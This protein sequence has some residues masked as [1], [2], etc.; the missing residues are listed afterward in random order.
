MGAE[1]LLRGAAGVCVNIFGKSHRLK[2]RG[3][4]PSGPCDVAS[5]RDDERD[6]EEDGA[7]LFHEGDGGKCRV[8]SE[9]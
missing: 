2:G 1:V 8:I 7:A 3:W 6:E 5:E 4:V 9:Q